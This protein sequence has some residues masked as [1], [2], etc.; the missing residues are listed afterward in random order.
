M[1]SVKEQVLHQDKN[2]DVDLIRRQV[3]YQVVVQVHDTGLVRR[4][5]WGQVGRPVWSQVV[6]GSYYEVVN[7]SYYEISKNTS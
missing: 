3:K 6:N 5:V 4:Q 7:G 2:Q 1:I